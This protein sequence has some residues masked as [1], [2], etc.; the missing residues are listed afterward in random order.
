[1]VNLAF[2]RGKLFAAVK[3]QEIPAWAAEFDANSWAQ[4]FLKYVVSHPAVICAIPG[5]TKLRHL[6]DNLGAA[7]GRLPTSEQRGQMEQYFAQ[8]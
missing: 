2:G 5:T 4:F 8:L 3:G 1:M 6:Q 7:R